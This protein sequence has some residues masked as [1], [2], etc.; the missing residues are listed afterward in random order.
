MG[1][2]SAKVGGQ[3]LPGV[4]GKFDRGVQNEAE[5]MLTEFC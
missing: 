2:Q 1:D 4:T 5:Q 3:E